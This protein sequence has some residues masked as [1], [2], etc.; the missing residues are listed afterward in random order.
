M[1]KKRIKKNLGIVIHVLTNGEAI[2]LE[3]RDISVE[4]VNPYGQRAFVEG[5]E[6]QD[7][8]IAFTFRA[9][10]Q[11]KLGVWKFIVW[12]NYGKDGQTV[13]D[14]ERALQLVAS[15]DLETPAGHEPGLDVDRV[16]LNV[17]DIEVG[18]KGDKGDDGKSL[19]E[20]MVSEGRFSGT[21]QEFLDAQEQAMKQAGVE[22]TEEVVQQTRQ[23]VEKLVED[24]E[25]TTSYLVEQTRNA[26][27]KAIADAEKATE[28]AMA[29]KGE[30]EA[31]E[32]QRKQAE[33]ERG[34]KE[35]ERQQHEEARET[36][37]AER[38]QV[39]EQNEQSRQQ[40]FEQNEQQ[41]SQTFQQGEQSRQQTADDAET[42]REQGF[43]TAQ[44][45]RDAEFQSKESQ[46]DAAMQTISQEAQKL[47]ELESKV[48]ELENGEKQVLTFLRGSTAIPCDFKQGHIYKC[49]F[50]RYIPYTSESP[51]PMKVTLKGD[52]VTNSY[53]PK[54]NE[55]YLS[56]G[57][58]Y[59]YVSPNNYTSVDSY[60]DG[61][62][63][64]DVYDITEQ[65]ED[66]FRM[67]REAEFAPNGDAQYDSLGNIIQQSVL[68]SNG[69]SGVL[70]R[71]LF[72]EDSF[73]FNKEEVTCINAIGGV[74]S[75][76]ATFENEFDDYGNISSKNITISKI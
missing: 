69:C 46:R 70:V 73:E 67:M 65:S 63:E 60:S 19:Y 32:L 44:Q 15:T 50:A 43:Q 14:R 7:N 64:W 22:A 41:R 49:T 58:T 16:D 55:V 27:T 3:G 51:I 40:V 17:V 61:T 10:E 37:E 26:T 59:Y 74:L 39:F 36:K 71:S 56:Y 29:A 8:R 18:I 33:N 75:Y 20:L 47:T 57:D 4:R 5:I 24:T 28:D 35:L 12:E 9:S 66:V 53:I 21:L 62:S 6:M 11:N 72:N 48:D 25:K 34:Q 68:W 76:K 38:Q 45:E 54:E 13:V 1:I 42:Q 2:S 31:S 30:M 52:N 23:N